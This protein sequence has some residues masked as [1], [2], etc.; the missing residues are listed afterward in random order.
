MALKTFQIVKLKQK[1]S[2]IF[3]VLFLLFFLFCFVFFGLCF[4]IHEL[5]NLFAFNFM[6]INPADSHFSATALSDHVLSIFFDNSS[7][8][9]RN[10]YSM[11]ISKI[12]SHLQSDTIFKQQ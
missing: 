3:K 4:L 1:V 9:A 11:N 8:P 7:C 12:K 2:A 10:R 5:S 6:E